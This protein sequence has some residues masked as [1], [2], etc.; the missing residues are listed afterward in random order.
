MIFFQSVV[1]VVVDLRIKIIQSSCV[2]I[3]FLSQTRCLIYIRKLPFLFRFLQPVSVFLSGDTGDL[4]C[5]LRIVL[6][7][8]RGNG[9]ESLLCQSLCIFLRLCVVLSSHHR[10]GYPHGQC[11]LIQMCLLILLYVEDPGNRKSGDQYGCDG[12]NL[13]QPSPL[14]PSD[15]IFRSF[16]LRPLMDRIRKLV[17][18]METQFLTKCHSLHDRIAQLLRNLRIHFHYIRHLIILHT[19]RALIRLCTGQHIVKS[20]RQGIDVC[21]WSLFTFR[22]VLL[23][24]C[25]P[26]SQHDGPGELSVFT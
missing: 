14:L 24:R 19:I 17:H 13:D 4:Q 12:Q 3:C 20:R 2:L 26:G 1:L 22:L 6:S 9:P 15:L 23:R 11:C 5:D 25:K 10:V 8:I 18:R 7:V 16:N 21:P